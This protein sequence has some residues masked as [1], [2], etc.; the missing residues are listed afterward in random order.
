VAEQVADQGAEQRDAGD[1]LDPADQRWMSS[2]IGVIDPMS[3]PMLVTRTPT[4]VRGPPI[5][6]PA[7]ASWML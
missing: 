4:M 2:S 1:V 6:E 3:L 5:S 7:V